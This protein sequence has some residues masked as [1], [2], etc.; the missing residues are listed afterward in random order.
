M[1]AESHHLPS[2]AK[3]RRQVP[4]AHICLRVRQLDAMPCFAEFRRSPVLCRYGADTCCCPRLWCRLY[5]GLG[6]C[7]LLV[8]LC[9]RLLHTVTLVAAEAGEQLFPLPRQHAQPEC[10]VVIGTLRSCA[11]TDSAGIGTA[12]PLTVYPPYTMGQERTS[13]DRGGCGLSAKHR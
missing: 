13:T 9:A 10:P 7:G 6:T 3:P 1:T 2:S 4:P 12:I 8:S 5:L 11:V